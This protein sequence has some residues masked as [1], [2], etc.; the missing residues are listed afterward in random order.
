ML[1]DTGWI[2]VAEGEAVF[3]AEVEAVG[4]KNGTGVKLA[5]GVDSKAGSSA[6]SAV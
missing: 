2:G 1:P 3:W 4:V 6:A 5:E